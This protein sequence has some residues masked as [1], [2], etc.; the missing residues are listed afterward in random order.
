[1]SITPPLDC[2][3]LHKYEYKTVAAGVTETII[4]YPLSGGYVGFIEKIACDLPTEEET[5]GAIAKMWHDFIV[6]GVHT[7][8]QY[9]IPINKPR[10]YDPPKVARNK[11]EWRFYNADSKAHI[12]GI[13]VEGRLCKLKT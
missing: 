7:K 6:D 1:M 12:I 2:L 5:V 8:I 3:E 11:I 9:E 13:L 10:T 4:D